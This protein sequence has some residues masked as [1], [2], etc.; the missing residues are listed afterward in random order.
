MHSGSSKDGLPIGGVT[1]YHTWRCKTLG[2][3]EEASLYSCFLIQEEN[4]LPN[5]ILYMAL[6][7]H[8]VWMS[9]LAMYRLTPCHQK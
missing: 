5:R 7:M 6:A 2:D 9:H 1:G 8:Q 4:H 3:K